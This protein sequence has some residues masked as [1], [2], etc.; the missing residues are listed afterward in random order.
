MTR[1]SAGSALAFERSAPGEPV[2]DGGEVGGVVVELP[3][4][5]A[6]R[7]RLAGGEAEQD[8]DLGG[9]QAERGRV[10]GPVLAQ[11]LGDGEQPEV[12]VEHPREVLVGRRW[13]VRIG[14]HRR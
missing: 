2:D 12:G 7:D 10:R 5:L 14:D 8:L 9:G 6:H 11:A 1:R 4:E 3:G 13:H